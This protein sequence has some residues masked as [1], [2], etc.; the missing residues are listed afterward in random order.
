MCGRRFESQSGRKAFNIY[1]YSLA[2]THSK[3]LSHLIVG[4]W[5]SCVVSRGHVIQGAEYVQDDG[6][7]NMRTNLRLVQKRRNDPV[8]GK[9]YFG[10][11]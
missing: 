7:N 10:E 6:V 4:R 8:N 3:Y 9:H 11:A 2:Y 1:H 5:I